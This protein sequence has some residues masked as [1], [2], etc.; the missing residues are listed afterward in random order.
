MAFLRPDGR[1]F[2]LDSERFLGNGTTGI[3]LQHGAYALKVPKIRDTS[4]LSADERASQDYVNNVNRDILEREK[5]VYQRL[6]S[7]DGI[8]KVIRM[9]EE[10][11]LLECHK[12]DLETHIKNEAEPG[13][14]CKATWIL[15]IIRTICHI[16]SS[17]VLVDDIALRNFLIAD[18]MS[19][20]MIDFGQCSLFPQDI[21]ITTAS[22]NGMTVQADLFHLGCLVYSI[23]AWRKY[24]CNLFE[25]H[26]QRPALDD[27]PVL[28][29]LLFRQAIKKCWTAQYRTTN[30]LYTGVRGILNACHELG[31]DRTREDDWRGRTKCIEPV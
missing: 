10:G 20:K 28:D 6:G 19:L 5:V 16:H 9:S 11:I 29:H 13:L 22:D 17:N 30:E 31:S 23:M 4:K 1:P 27:L 21:D 26:F 15:S 2:D 24:E 12:R 7:C 8:V 18:D 14:A 3:V 25:R